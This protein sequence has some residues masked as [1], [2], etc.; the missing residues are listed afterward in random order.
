M[1]ATSVAALRAAN[2]S[3]P[4]VRAVFT[5]IAAGEAAEHAERSFDLAAW[6]AYGAAA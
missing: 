4:E 2:A 5:Q 6:P 1:A 3:D